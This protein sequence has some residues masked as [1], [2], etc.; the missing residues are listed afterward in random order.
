MKDKKKKKNLHN[1]WQWRPVQKPKVV[2]LDKKRTVKEPQERLPIIIR[3]FVPKGLS[4]LFT[5]FGSPL[6]YTVKDWTSSTYKF[7]VCDRVSSNPYRDPDSR[8]QTLISRF[9][10]EGWPYNRWSLNRP[11]GFQTVGRK[12]NRRRE[13]TVGTFDLRFNVYYR[14]LNRVYRRTMI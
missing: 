10:R 5:I 7:S 2:G 6:Y 1:D 4:Q 3:T 9:V 12:T 11:C 8:P 13:P 14:K